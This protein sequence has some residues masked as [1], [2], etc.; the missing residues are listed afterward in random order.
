TA[1]REPPPWPTNAVSG[2]PPTLGQP[3]RRADV[4]RTRRPL[5]RTPRPRHR[6]PPRTAIG[7]TPMPSSPRERWQGPCLAPHPSDAPSAAE[8]HRSLVAAVG[9]VVGILPRPTSEASE[10]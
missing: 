3:T 10:M 7:R 6:L 8:R 2:P 9:A 1:P 4:R 5:P